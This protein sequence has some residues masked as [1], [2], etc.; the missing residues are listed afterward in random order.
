MARYLIEDGWALP[1]NPRHAISPGRAMIQKLGVGEAFL[2]PKDDY[3]KVYSAYR[4]ENHEGGQG[5]KFNI[6]RFSQSQY[7]IERLL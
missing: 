1:P 3:K 2:F 6:R 5:K 7:K 4:K